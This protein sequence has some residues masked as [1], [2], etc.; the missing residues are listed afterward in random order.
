MRVSIDQLIRL[1]I[2]EA[3]INRRLIVGLFVVINLTMVGVG[4][5]WQRGAAYL[6][7]TTIMIDEK[8]II[9]PLMAGAAVT[10]DIRD[11]AKIA[12]EI[13][14]GHKIM[15][16][17]MESRGLDPATLSP[18]KQQEFLESMELRTRIASVGPNLIRIEFRDPDPQQ[19]YQTTKKIADLFI[20]EALDAKAK[21]SRAAYEFIEAQ[22]E[23]Y[24]EKLTQAEERLKEYRSANLDA[25]AG[26]EAQVGA[27]IDGLQKSIDETKQL[28]NEA[29]IKRASLQRQ[30][31]G[32]AE[33]AM[34][35]TREGQ[36]RARI[37]ELQAQI[38]QLRL[39]YHDSYPD[40][41][42]LRHQIEDLNEAIVKDR[43][44]RAVARAAGREV[45]E[46][47]LVHNPLYQQIRSEISKASVEIATLQAR[48]ADYN[49]QLREEL[50]R[51]RRVNV[52]EVTL[53]EVTRDYEV[54][55]DIYRDLLKRR[56]AAR[57]SM[58]LDRDQQGVALKIQEPASVPIQANGL[59]FIHFALAGLVLGLAAPIGMVLAKIQLDP[60]IRLPAVISDQLKLPL[61]ANIPHL[62]SPTETA[63]VRREMGW[64][65]MILILNGVAF[66]AAGTLRMMGVI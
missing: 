63:M 64:L 27:R 37:S 30:L 57:V 13:V 23:E 28:L 55:R 56:E 35:L 39:N 10:T 6:S 49:R 50:E 31:S 58:N 54:N 65:V 2:N 18:K 25:R 12:R 52:G 26:T 22:A 9:Q 17:V 41:V 61:I 43:Q 8:N 36:Y 4:L 42:R 32:E 1:G 5:A 7:S 38:D 19:A 44:E 34:A 60:R 51:G 45:Q 14:F 46:Q 16:Q 11:R 29:D 48:L 20:S 47:V 53:A 62:A 21:E 40:I 59:R 3:F 15:H 24:L 66:V 33:S